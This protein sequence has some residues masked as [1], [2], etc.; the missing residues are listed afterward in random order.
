MDVGS[1]GAPRK[2]AVVQLCLE[3]S[4]CD[5]MQIVHSRIP[6]SL[7]TILEDP[8]IVKVTSHALKPVQL[9]TLQAV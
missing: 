6:S 1:G 3:S 7:A 5:V 4:R 8:S 9:C 2:V